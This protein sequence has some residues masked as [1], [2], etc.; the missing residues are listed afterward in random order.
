MDERAEKETVEN[1]RYK[2]KVL[3]TAYFTLRKRPETEA[4]V[5]SVLARHGSRRSRSASA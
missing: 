2:T 4:G 1:A 3:K 5:A